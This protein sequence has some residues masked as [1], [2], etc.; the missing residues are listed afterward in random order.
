MTLTVIGVGAGGTGVAAAN[1][2]ANPG[3][4][5]GR[6]LTAMTTA[7]KSRITTSANKKKIPPLRFVPGAMVAS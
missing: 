4:M 3:S 6:N 2:G 7:T 1:F 5:P